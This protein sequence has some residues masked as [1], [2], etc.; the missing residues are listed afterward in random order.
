MNAL[1]FV[2]AVLYFVPALIGLGKRN[3]LG[4][5]FLNLVFGWTVIGWIA[6][7]IWACV[8]PETAVAHSGGESGEAADAPNARDD[9]TARTLAYGV[10][11][12]IAV[13]GA[14]YFLSRNAAAP[15]PPAPIVQTADAAASPPCAAS[16]F[17]I[18]KKREWTDDADFMHVVGTV[19]NN[20]RVPRAVELVWRGTEKDGTIAFIDD[21]FA[22]EQHAV[23]P[24][25]SAHFEEL[26]P[27][28]IVDKLY[29]TV[30]VNRLYDFG[31]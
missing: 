16:D 14:I 26:R 1:F 31:G 15:P 24:G 22:N 13:F 25:A 29:W 7:F 18:V 2:A 5:A 3:W 23:P 9:S 11:G 28:P 17:A 20:C 21:F 4:I 10:A 27:R 6:A 12:A 19:K 8:S 30:D